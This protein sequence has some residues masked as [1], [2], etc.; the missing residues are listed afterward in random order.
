[1]V[2]RLFHGLNRAKNAISIITVGNPEVFDVLLSIA[3][4]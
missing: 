1:M 4:G 2:R 3:Q